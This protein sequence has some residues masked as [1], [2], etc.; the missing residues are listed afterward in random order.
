MTGSRIFDIHQHF[1][2][3]QVAQGP[4]MPD[5]EW[6]LDQDYRQRIAIMDRF[7]IDQCAMS[8]TQQYERPTG[9]PDTRRFNNLAA[10]Y[11]RRYRDRFPVAL[12]TVEL[13]H[14]EKEGLAELER[15]AGELRLDGV[16]WHHHFQGTAMV[17]RRMWPF[18]KKTAELKLPAFVHV[19][20]ES[21]LESAWQLEVLADAFP[22][23][24]FIG[25]A[26]MTQLTQCRYLLGICRRCPNIHLDT[27]ALFSLGRVLEEFIEHIGSERIV[28]GSDLYLDPLTYEVPY[29]LLGIRESR[30]IPAHDKEN[31]LWNNARRLFRLPG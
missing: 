29:V 20:A 16:V 4:A 26:G 14:G 6:N 21:M 7:G 9:Q 2:L 25:L 15:I 3:V 18:L 11:K 10:E 17:D 1:G 24:T 27:A 31:I 28:F 5:A 8:P 30:G 13:L 12:G 23:V 19:M 22:E